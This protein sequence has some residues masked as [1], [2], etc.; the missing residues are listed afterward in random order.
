[1][2]DHNLIHQSM[3]VPVIDLSLLL[4]QDSQEKSLVIKEIHEACQ[5]SGIFHVINHGISQEVIEEALEVNRNF[6]DL[7]DIMKKDILEFGSGDP[8]SPVKFA[9]FKQRAHGSDLLQRDVLRINANPIDEF[10]DLWPKNP[11]DYREKMGRYTQEVRKLGN[12]LFE[13]IMESLNLGGATHLQENF[14]KG[15]QLVATNCYNSPH[16]ESPSIKKGTPPHTDFGLITILL[17]TSPGLEIL[18]SFD[19]KWKSAPKLE[20][21]SFQVFV[22]D[23]LEVLSNGKYKSVMHQVI[24][25]SSTTETRMSIASFHSFDMDDIVEPAINLVEEEGVKRYKDCSAKE[26]L[27]LVFSR[28]FARPIE[29]LKIEM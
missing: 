6:F 5:K 13:A 2:N 15:M 23:L 4:S 1:M 12:Q 9:T 26:L 19:G 25:P 14:G 24:V 20:E 7:P 11:A 27:K 16:Q 21:G 28:G 29:A 3:N 10:L 17:Q 18:D 8:F 22:G